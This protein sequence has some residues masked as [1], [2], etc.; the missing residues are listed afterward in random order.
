MG[1]NG[2][3]GTDDGTKV[4]S[5]HCLH[6]R[7]ESCIACRVLLLTLAQGDT[8]IACTSDKTVH[9]LHSVMK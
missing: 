6:G 5:K 2:S 1:L 8:A 4:P 3:C 9:D 7:E